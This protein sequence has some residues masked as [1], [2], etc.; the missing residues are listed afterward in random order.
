MIHIPRTKPGKQRPGRKKQWRSTIAASMAAAALP[1]AAGLALTTTHAGGPTQTSLT[2]YAGSTHSQPE[3]TGNESAVTGGALF[4]GNVALTREAGKLD[5]RLAVIRIYDHIGDTFPGPYRKL[6]AAGS[7]AAVSLDSSGASYAAIAAGH[8]DKAIGAFLRS[9]NQAAIRYHLPAIYVSFEHEPDIAKHRR[10]GTPAQFVQAWD[11]IHRLAA[12]AHLDWKTG[13]RLHWV[14]ILL[15]SAFSN[16]LASKFWPGGS[17]VAGIGVDGYNSL[18]CRMAADHGR[19][20]RRQRDLNTPGAIFGPAL[21]FA[22][23]KGGVP[24]FITEWGSD[25]PGGSGTQPTFIRQM[26]SYLTHNREIAAAMYWDS[27][28]PACR[29]S[30]DNRPAS[31]AALAA[32]G[33]SPALQGRITAPGL[34]IWC[35]PLPVPMSQ[36]SAPASGQGY[37]VCPF[38]GNPSPMELPCW[39]AGPR[40]GVSGIACARVYRMLARSP[41]D[42]Q[43][44]G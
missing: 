26:Q 2:A 22:G 12:S 35:G 16:G 42:S 36:G 7:T 11:H 21:S 40:P 31:L 39:Q 25:T 19:V 6:L 24:V 38:T 5:R 3:G 44:R 17:E 13:G 14:W 30:V 1:A 32:M 4:G 37:R 27:N 15:H 8:Q 29:Y 20:P 41:R 10:L 33:H 34:R 43:A 18:A 9:V 23:S 28:G